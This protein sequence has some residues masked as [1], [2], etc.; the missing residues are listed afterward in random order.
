MKN[1]HK[2]DF[3]KSCLKR[4]EFT[5]LFLKYYKNKIIFKKLEN[6]S[7]IIKFF[8]RK[9]NIELFKKKEDNNQNKTKTIQKNCIK[10]QK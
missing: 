10:P 6:L 9:Y 7:Q 1:D 4:L 2:N 8:E 5:S 3:R